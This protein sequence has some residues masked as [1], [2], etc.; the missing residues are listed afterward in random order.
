[1]TVTPAAQTA[2][3]KRLSSWVLVLFGL[4][5]LSI[6]IAAARDFRRPNPY[7]YRAGYHEDLYTM[8][9]PGTYGNLIRLP[10]LYPGDIPPL[11][12][13]GSNQSSGVVSVASASST[14]GQQSAS[15]STGSVSFAPKVVVGDDTAGPGGT[16]LPTGRSG[17]LSDSLDS[18]LR[19]AIRRLHSK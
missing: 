4:M 3:R 16:L 2:A 11:N 7:D 13:S 12:S 1:M 18:G 10:S 19:D 5:V 9:C 8:R 6:G 17:S 14:G 15:P